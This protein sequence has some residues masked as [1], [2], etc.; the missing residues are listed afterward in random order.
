GAARHALGRQKGL[1]HAG[2]HDRAE[3]APRD[4]ERERPLHLLAGAHAARADDAFRRIVGEVGVRLVLAWVG[5]LVAVIAVA[6]VAQ[7][8]RAGH[9]LQLAVAVGRAGQAIERVIGNVELHDAAAQALEALGLRAH[10]HAGRDRRGAGGR[11][12]GAALD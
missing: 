3:A 1:L 9:V 4:G 11:R 7:A 5:V 10:H 12:A 8:D 6:D 2:R